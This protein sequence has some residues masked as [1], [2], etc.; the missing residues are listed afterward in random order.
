MPLSPQAA[1]SPRQNQVAPLPA[2]LS[3]EEADDSAVSAI[4]AAAAAAN[5]SPSPDASGRASGSPLK[6]GG[7]PYFHQA[8][9]HIVKIEKSAGY[10]FD[11]TFGMFAC[12]EILPELIARFEALDEDGSGEV[13]VSELEEL[14]EAAGEKLNPLELESV[15]QEFDE[16]GSGFITVDEFLNT[17]HKR[18]LRQNEAEIDIAEAFAFLDT[19]HDGI[20]DVDE[21]AAQMQAVM[22]VKLPADEIRSICKV[23]LS[24]NPRGL[25]IEDFTYLVNWKPAQE[26]GAVVQEVQEEESSGSSDTDD[27]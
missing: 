14:L 15:F 21:V 22:R 9:E 12:K 7:A 5:P 8:E 27:Y 4:N 17:M 10:Q 1:A 20:I 18:W 26:Q 13:D 2:D 19:D 25:T 11:P 16:D 6:H 3:L 23:S 24:K